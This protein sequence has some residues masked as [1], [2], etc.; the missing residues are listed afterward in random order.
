[1]YWSQSGYA[2][3]C[4]IIMSMDGYI[5]LEMLGEEDVSEV[6]ESA[7]DAADGHWSEEFLH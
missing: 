6:S 5:W 1:M 4:A 2:A 3:R 7:D